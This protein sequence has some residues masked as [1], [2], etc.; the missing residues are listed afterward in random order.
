MYAPAALLFVATV[1]MLTVSNWPA[2][3]LF[4][5]TVKIATVCVNGCK[6]YILLQPA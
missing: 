1:K 6:S 2:V 4:V 3:M 5:A